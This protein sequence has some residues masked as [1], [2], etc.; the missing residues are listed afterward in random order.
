MITGKLN[1]GEVRSPKSNG[2]YRYELLHQLHNLYT[3]KKNLKKLQKI[4]N[5]LKSCSFEP[6]LYDSRKN[7]ESRYLTSTRKTYE[8]P[9]F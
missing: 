5:E 9:V 2:K 3:Y 4:D 7:V 1:E 6:E 8:M